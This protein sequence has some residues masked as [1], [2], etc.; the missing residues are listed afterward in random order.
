[1]TWRESFLKLRAA[2]LFQYDR[3]I[4]FDVDAFPLAS[5]DNLFDIAKFPV[6]IAAPRAACV[7]DISALRAEWRSNGD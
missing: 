6:E 2:E 4:Y 5:L 7:L 3:V 1:M